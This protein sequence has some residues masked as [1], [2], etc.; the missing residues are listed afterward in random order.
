MSMQFHW[1][2]FSSLWAERCALSFSRPIRVP[3]SLP[4]LFK[5]VLAF[6]AAERLFNDAITAFIVAK[7]NG[8]EIFMENAVLNQ[9]IVKN[10]LLN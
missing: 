6:K 10:F 7:K 9:H 5:K 4:Y 2:F 1:R 8:N 3:P